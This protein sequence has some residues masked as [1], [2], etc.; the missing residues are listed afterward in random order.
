MGR[1]RINNCGTDDE[2][3]AVDLH[4]LERENHIGKNVTLKKKK[5]VKASAPSS[6]C[7][8]VSGCMYISFCLQKKEKRG[9]GREEETENFA[10]QKA[11]EAGV[12]QESS[13]LSRNP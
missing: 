1:R 12:D 13:V 11:E 4:F 10:S 8:K 6:Y 7:S 9:R 3:R 2:N 5:K